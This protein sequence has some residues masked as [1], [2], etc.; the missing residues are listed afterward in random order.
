MGKSVE[1]KPYINRESKS[2]EITMFYT[3]VMMKMKLLE[4]LTS[5][6]IY[7]GLSNRKTF[8]EEKFTGEEKFTLGNLSAVNMENCD[9]CNVR[10]HRDIKGCDKYV[11]LKIFLKS[12]SMYKMIIT[13]S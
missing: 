8:W 11:I 10:K 2:L 3:S 4:V 12:D 6:Y 9:C 5:T 1:G 7:H 13:Y